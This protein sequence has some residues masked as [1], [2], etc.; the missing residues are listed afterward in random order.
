MKSFSSFNFQFSTRFRAY[1]PHYVPN[2]RLAFPVVLSQAGQMIVGIADTVMVGRLGAV[3][4]A[5]VSLANNIFI[6][7]MVFG[8]G[9]VSGLTP[10][11]GKDF[12]AGNRLCATSWLKQSAVM[13]PAIGIAQM[14]LMALIALLM[15]YMGQP[16]EVVQMATPYYMTL[17]ASLVPLQCFMVFKQYA[18]GLGNTRIAM[19]ITIAANGLNIALNYLLIYGK[20]GLPAMGA[21]GAGVAT[22]VS[23]LLM[24]AAFALLFIKLPFFRADRE[25]WRRAKLSKR[26][27][28]RLFR[29]GIPIAGQSIVEV[30]T[31]SIGS[32]MMGW[33]GAT[34]LAAHQVV[35]SL[36]SF[37][38]MVS[39]GFATAATIKVSHF[40]GMGKPRT[41][42]V[43]ALASLHQVLLFMAVNVTLFILLRYKIPA[44]FVPDDEVIRIAA[45]LMFIA[46]LYQLFDGMQVVMLGALR[47]YEDVRVPMMIVM[48][49]Y[50][51]VALPVCYLMTF[52]LNMGPAGVW[53]GYLVGLSLVAALLWR[54][55]RR[56]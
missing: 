42:R 12:A 46:G 18:D 4:L 14:A 55:F 20:M 3:P 23:R 40:R 43:S 9:L 6:I 27:A 53:V 13:F 8:I 26:L 33:L 45:L 32:F 39:M 41:A 51:F 2:F 48:V 29:L 11:A 56:K 38:Y 52:T 36:S 22:L 37:T 10:L 16:A 25:G 19:F 24:A 28:T 31:F 1:R 34:A 50:Y 44:L 15:P 49:I 54:R 7:G 17:V 21:T 5:A 47:G 30:S 35:I